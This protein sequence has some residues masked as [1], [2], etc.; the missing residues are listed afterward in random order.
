[1]AATEHVPAARPVKVLP[2]TLQMD[3]VRL[4]NTTGSFDDALALS[5]PVP[6]T[7]KLGNAL[8]V[9]VWFNFAEKLAMMRQLLV[10]GPVV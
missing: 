4:L 10:I 2:E 3:E 8:K 6:P 7:T 1:L 5:A 9:M